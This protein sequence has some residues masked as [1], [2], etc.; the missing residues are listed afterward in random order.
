MR[1]IKFRQWNPIYK[2]FQYDIGAAPENDGVWTCPQYVSWKRYPLYE[3]TGLHDRNGKE[4]WEGDIGKLDDGCCDPI[5]EDIQFHNGAFC[6][7]YV[8]LSAMDMSIV[9][10]I[11]NIYD[12]PEL[13]K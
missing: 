7:G 1:T 10:V 13:L 5:V 9:E 6:Q 12:N 8:P 11:G 4:I 2:R 3:F